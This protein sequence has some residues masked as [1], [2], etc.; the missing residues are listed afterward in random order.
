MEITYISR[1]QII[2]VW[3]ERKSRNDAFVTLQNSDFLQR[4]AVP[5]VQIYLVVLIEKTE[6]KQ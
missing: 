2:S 3:G 6:V 1:S 4:F 5:L